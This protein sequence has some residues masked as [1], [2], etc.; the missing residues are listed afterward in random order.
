MTQWDAH[1]VWS[2]QHA[3]LAMLC[4]SLWSIQNRERSH[5]KL[6]VRR[7]LEFIF[8]RD[9]GVTRATGK[10]PRIRAN[11]CFHNA[12]GIEPTELD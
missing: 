1:E 2:V 3:E 5:T 6:Y 4:P 7:E 12:K 8:C 9:G 11:Y 10:H